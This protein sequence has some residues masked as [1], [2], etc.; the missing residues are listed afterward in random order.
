MD[1]RTEFQIVFMDKLIKSPRKDLS[2]SKNLFWD[3]L[4]WVSI[5]FRNVH[6]DGGTARRDSLVV[7]YL[8]YGVVES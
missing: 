4:Q 2:G 1:V 5:I 6:V 3:K 8:T 7:A